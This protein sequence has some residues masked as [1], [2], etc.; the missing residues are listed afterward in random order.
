MPGSPVTKT[1]DGVGIGLIGQTESLKLDRTKETT[2]QL[3]IAGLMNAPEGFWG[4]TDYA[5]DRRT[6]PFFD[7]KKDNVGPLTLAA[8]V[9][10]GASRD[11]N[12]KLETARMVV[13]GNGDLLSMQGLQA[14]P[15]ALD[16]ATNAF[17]WLLN[18]DSLIAIAA[19]PK[20]NVQISLNEGQLLDLAKWV[21]LYIPLIIGLF[22][23]YYLWARN[24]KSVLKLTMT[25]AFS[26]VLCWLLWRLLLRY[27]GSAEGRHI[28]RDSLIFVGVVFIVGAAAFVLQKTLRQKPQTQKN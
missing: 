17:N 24:G 16:L 21:S 23:L 27:L 5:G 28:S 22:G 2:D 11:P 13:I 6:T 15:A 26:F 10:K 9:E 19:K 18:R 7:P 3:R 8:A 4:E 20:Q 14:G 25:V 1:L 12:V